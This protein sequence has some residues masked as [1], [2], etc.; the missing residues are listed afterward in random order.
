MAAGRDK[1]NETANAD[2]GAHVERSALLEA[3]YA[4]VLDLVSR[5]TDFVDAMRSGVLP[6]PVAEAGPA[7]TIES[8][9]HTT[10][11]MQV[12]AWLLTQRAVDS[13][14]MTEEE[15]AD[16]KYRLGA[17]DICLASPMAGAEELPKTFREMIIRSRQI[18]RRMK[19]LADQK[20]EPAR[21]HPIHTL[22]ERLDSADS[23]DESES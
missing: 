12:M 2:A 19:R 8:M 11:L 4:D 6:A 15:A 10:R 5:T 18:Y 17:E 1:T 21:E 9:R 20:D 23:D 16:P 13:G 14:E 7:Y 22:M 3:T